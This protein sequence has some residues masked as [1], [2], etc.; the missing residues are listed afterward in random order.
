VLALVA[1]PLGIQ[2]PRTQ[3]TWGTGLS[4]VLG[5]GVFVLYYGSLSIG[6]AMGE[7][8]RLDPNVALWLPNAFAALLAAFTISKMASEKWQSITQ[9][10]EQ[11]IRGMLQRTRLRYATP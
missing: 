1:M 10:I 5:L 2:P 3:K 7:A 6:I 11:V 9:G 8:G 4:A